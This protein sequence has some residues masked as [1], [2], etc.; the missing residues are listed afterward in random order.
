MT[1]RVK[2][3]IKPSQGALATRLS[4]AAAPVDGSVIRTDGNGLVEGEFTAT[5]SDF[6]VPVYYA[7]PAG[8]GNKF[9]VVLVVSEVFGVHAHIA[10]VCRRFAKCGYLAMAPDLFARLGD[11][12]A[13]ASLADLMREIVSKTSDAQV[14]ADLDAVC[15]MAGRFGGDCNRL[16]VT[17]FC[18]GG[19]ITWLYVAHSRHVK[20]AVAWYGR[21]DGPASANSPVHPVALAHQLQ[22][23]VLGLYAGHDPVVPME[24]VASMRSALELGN[25]HARNSRIDI[26]P[27]AGHAFFA[28]YRESYREADALDGWAKCLA[29]FASHGAM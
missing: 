4:A 14:I 8:A 25:A 18:W 26:F 20:A 9:P 6:D 2:A 17:G 29:W 16:A 10:D 22:A 24:H 15:V 23:P 28:D 19:R 11:A 12:S 5:S 7:M 3:L 1:D 13:Y 27:D 21:L